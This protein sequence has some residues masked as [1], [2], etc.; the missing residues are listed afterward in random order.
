M[1]RKLLKSWWRTTNVLLAAILAAMGVSCEEPREE[2]GTPWASFTIKGRVIDAKTG[3]GV[4]GVLVKAVSTRMLEGSS[5]DHANRLW[6]G[7][8]S[9]R[10]ITAIDGSYRMESHTV[11]DGAF[12]VAAVDID[13]DVNGTLA[14]D[15]VKIDVTDRGEQT[16]SSDHWF[17]GAWEATLD[18][19][20][21]EKPQ[22]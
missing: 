12:T 1:K 15:T 4:E 22:E 18:F 7:S 11:P 8:T 5:D 2:Y 9:V 3:E 20:L 21:K 13:G 16:A 17:S 6:E 14:S 10:A 19:P